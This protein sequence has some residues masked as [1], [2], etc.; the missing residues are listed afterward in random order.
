MTRRAPVGGYLAL[1]ILFMVG[2]HRV[3]AADEDQQGLRFWTKARQILISH[4]AADQSRHGRSRERARIRAHRIAELV[5]GSKQGFADIAKKVSDSAEKANGGLLPAFRV[6]NLDLKL[7]EAVNGMRVG[8][9]IGPIET[10]FGFHIFKR[11]AH[12]EVAISQLLFS[13][14]GASRSPKS[15]VRSQES[16]GREARERLKAFQGGAEFT[17]EHLGVVVADYLPAELSKAIEPLKEGELCFVETDFGYHIVRREPIELATGWHILI[18][19][20]R[21]FQ[22]KSARSRAEAARLA[23]KLL[24]ELQIK[25][26]RFVEIH[27]AHS[28]DRRLSLGVIPR[29][30][31]QAL[32]LIQEAIFELKAGQ[33]CGRVLE[34]R[35]GFHLILRRG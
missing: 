34:S 32:E 35:Y 31:P 25:P 15:E 11:E 1:S 16:A 7:A 12:R 20:E 26:S 33:V 6:Q 14:K 23:K 10:R 21:G 13:Y 5:K 29:H 17:G 22:S 28:G 18:E 24:A 8:Q 9:V 19:H 30:G 3:K 2:A 27:K 4:K